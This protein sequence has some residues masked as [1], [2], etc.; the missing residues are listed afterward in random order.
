MLVQDSIIH[1]KHLFPILDEML[2]DLLPSLTKEEWNNSTIA[3]QWTVKDIAAHLLDTNLRTLSFARD[4]HQL[5]PNTSVEKYSD[6]IAY[7]N[8][9][10]ADWVQALKRLSTT[11]LIDLLKNS[12]REFCEFMQSADLDSEAI[13]SVAWAGEAS[14]KNWFHI[15]REYTEKFIHQQQIRDAVNKPALITKELFYPFIDTFMRALPYTY[16]N[17]NAP[18]GTVV[19]VTITSEAGG[20]WFLKRTNNNWILVSEP[21]EKLSTLVTISPSIAWKLFSKGIS[22]AE[23]KADV[24]IDGDQELGNVVLTM[25]SVMA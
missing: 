5:V 16:R 9:L 23:A 19:S 3:K 13:F 6:L 17:T 1:T 11:V 4:G 7:L 22:P 10:N 12:G 25:V 20:S 14:S 8:K 18:E 15:A 2:I 24:M 21:E